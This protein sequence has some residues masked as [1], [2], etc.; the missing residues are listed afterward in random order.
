M[1]DMLELVFIIDRSG[2]MAR[3]VSDTIGGFNSVLEKQKETSGS[4]VLVSTVLFD[5]TSDVIHNRIPIRDVKPLDSET[6]QVRGTT[7]LLDAVG[8]AIEHIKRVHRYLGEVDRPSKTMFVITTDGLE[9]AS[10]NY[11]RSNISNMIQ[12]QTELG[13]E[14]IYLGANVDAYQEAAQMGIRKERTA[15]YIHDAQGVNH[16]YMASNEAISHLRSGKIH[17][18]WKNIVDQDYINRKK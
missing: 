9:N 3:L 11:K 15:N 17:K 1:R 6:Y 4:E 16:S 5:H 10:M 14:F 13:W 8:G 12:Q 2:S 18:N 7:A